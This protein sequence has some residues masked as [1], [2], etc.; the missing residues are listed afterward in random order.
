[1]NPWENKDNLNKFPN[2]L[3]EKFPEL[4]FIS[5]FADPTQIPEDLPHVCFMGRSNSGKSS[6]IAALCSNPG[7]V[8]TS[9]K[10]GQTRLL[11]VFRRENI[12]II[13]MP[14]YGYAKISKKE[15]DNLSRL[16]H[17]Y[18]TTANNL[19]GGFLLLD[20]KRPPEGEELYIQ[21]TFKESRIPLLLLM[22]KVDRF[23]QKEKAN[24]SKQVKGYEKNFPH[25]VNV[26]ATK[27]MN[28]GYIDNFL[29]T[30]G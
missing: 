13:D 14:G 12:Y 28:L 24:L 17:A 1:M 9:R 22:T 23:N 2:K 4:T 26:S 27:G 8:K 21:E 16:I 6:L 19:H 25:V 10:P 18:I 20:C 30:L 7:I 5:S 3:K 15:R 29:R 11:N